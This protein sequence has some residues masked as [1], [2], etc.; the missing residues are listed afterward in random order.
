MKK[1]ESTKFEF[2]LTLENN[3]ICQRYFTVKGYNPDVRRSLDLYYTVQKAVEQI[4]NNLK[5][6]AV[7]F[8]Y[9]TQNENF[10]KNKNN[11]NGE[12]E[13]LA[14]P[15]N[16]NFVLQ[17]KIGDDVVIAR[18]FSASI[19]PAKVRYTVDIRPEIRNI[20]NDITETMSLNEYDNVLSEFNF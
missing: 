17:I 20:L 13:Q 4:Q 8:L 2:L 7:E 9:E 1:N 10:Y 11:S 5:K 6:K 16:E 19:Y 3:I 14:E 12:N 18:Q 15:T